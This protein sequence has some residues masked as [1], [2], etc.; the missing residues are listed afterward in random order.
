MSIR[1]LVLASPQLL[2]RLESQRQAALKNVQGKATWVDLVCSKCF[3]SS[4]WGHAGT[5][6]IRAGAKSCL[7]LSIRFVNEVTLIDTMEV[8]WWRD[9]VLFFIKTSCKTQNWY[10]PSCGVL[11]RH[12]QFIVI[13]T[14]QTYLGYT[15]AQRKSRAEQIAYLVHK[16]TEKRTASK[17]LGL[18]TQSIIFLPRHCNRHPYGPIFH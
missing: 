8:M 11:I 2:P 12:F 6:L 13:I 15:E 10:V 9:V 3:R 17:A 18:K 14:H 4:P 5:I 1:P 7:S 16:G